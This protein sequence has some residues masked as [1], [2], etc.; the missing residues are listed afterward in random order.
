MGL[1]GFSVG[2]D[3]SPYRPM[4]PAGSMRLRFLILIIRER[5]IHTGPIGIRSTV[6]K[7][8]FIYSGG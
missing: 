2:V 1:P 7:E 8:F 5:I 4:D 6:F 3:S